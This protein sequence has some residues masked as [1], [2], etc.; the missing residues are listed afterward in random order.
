ML[1][2]QRR[3]FLHPRHGFAHRRDPA[4]NVLPQMRSFALAHFHHHIQRLAQCLFDRRPEA[5]RITQFFVALHHAG[6]AH[7]NVQ[8]DCPVQI[9][10]LGQPFQFAR[11]GMRQLFVDVSAGCVLAF[12][13]VQRHPG[14]Q[15]SARN[16]PVD[17]IADLRF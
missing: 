14:G 12:G 3:L 1:L 17:L 11:I 16:A 5:L 6:G 7:Q 10:F 13:E 9:K 8:R 2:H 15:P 4:A